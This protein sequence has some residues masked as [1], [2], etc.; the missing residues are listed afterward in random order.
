[1]YV[2][3]I[4]CTYSKTDTNMIMGVVVYP[5]NPKEDLGQY[6]IKIEG[7]WSDFANLGA[8]KDETTKKAALLKGIQKFSSSTFTNLITQPDLS[9]EKIKRAMVSAASFEKTKFE[10]GV[11]KCSEV[12]S[13]STGNCPQDKKPLKTRHVLCNKNAPDGPVTFL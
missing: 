8:T 11:R 13:L 1:M 10:N 4:L 9:Y 2:H 12:H 3:L 5:T 6:I 7:I